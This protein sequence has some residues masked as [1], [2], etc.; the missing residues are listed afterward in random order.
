MNSISTTTED[1]ADAVKGAA[2]HARD[3]LLELGTQLLRLLGRAREA[4][5]FSLDNWLQR[6]GLQ[7]RE[8]I[9]QPVLFFA[10]GAVLGAGAGLL[11]APTAGSKLREDIAAF[12]SGEIEKLTAMMKPVVEKTTEKVE[13]AGKVVRETEGGS[14]DARNIDNGAK[15]AST[16]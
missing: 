6:I 12:L 8:S 15:H 2:S 14:S 9:V 11:L 7:R 10:A 16:L 13:K 4:E 1:A 3:N 5:V